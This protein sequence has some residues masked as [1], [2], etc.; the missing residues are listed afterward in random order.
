[1][2]I[3][4]TLVGGVVGLFWER[5]SRGPTIAATPSTAPDVTVNLPIAK[6]VANRTGFLG[7]FSAVD[8]VEIRAQVG[9]VLTGIEF[10][11]GQ[12][13]KKG[14]PLFVIDPRPYEIRLT[15]AVAAVRTAEAQADLA[16][17]ELWR[18]QQL[19]QTNFGTAES[20]DQRISDLRVANAAVDTAN[21]NVRN[22]TLDFEY[23]HVAAPFTGRVS[24]HRVSI[25]SLISGSR[26]GTSPTTL[27]TTIVSTDPI[28]LNFDMSENDYL[29]FARAHP[30]GELEEQVDFRLGDEETETRRGSLDF[31][32]NTID[33]ASGTIHARATAPNPDGFLKPGSFA[34]LSLVTGQPR[35]SLLVPETALQLDQSN[36]VLMTVAADDTVVA[37]V[38]TVGD[39]DGGMRVITGG[40]L[41][42]DRVIVDGLVRA[43]P[44]QKVAPRKAPVAPK[45]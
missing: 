20:V 6:T 17:S 27:L 19:K 45:G 18:A 9:G 24:N 14:D 16:Q 33:R 28:Y 10:K 34:R 15:T 13:V 41:A 31:I 7:Q 25:G 4:V 26:A 1:M 11:D 35:P 8:A 43:I 38:V 2:V 39:L 42:T 30:D 5:Q 36:H 32:D 44:G 37:K 22:A 3:A 21:S 12:V 29:A 40:L 23:S